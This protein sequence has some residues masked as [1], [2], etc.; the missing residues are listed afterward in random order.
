M[1]PSSTDLVSMAAQRRAKIERYRQKKELESRLTDVQR[2][3]NSG[4]A[5]DEVT[6]DF[7]LLNIKKWITVGLEELESITQEVEIL[8]SMGGVNKGATKQP[9]QP[10]R[11]PMK[12]FILT[13]DA[14]Q[15]G[16][17]IVYDTKGAS[18]ILMAA[19]TDEP[20]PH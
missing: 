20:P 9:A 18:C 12:P 2:A 15:V 16:L 17:C 13:K 1:G 3:V 6:R 14:V 4:Q 7:Y 19:F 5:D 10:A 11:P 8:K